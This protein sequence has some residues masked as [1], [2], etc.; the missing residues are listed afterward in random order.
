[1]T[2]HFSLYE[3]L[4][5]PEDLDF[6]ARLYGMRNHKALVQQGIEELGLTERSQ[7]LEGTLSGGW[8]KRLALCCINSSAQTAIA[9][10]TNGRH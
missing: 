2:Q 9:Q 3:D 10:R 5:V 7:E 4:S 8:K 6:V 1:M